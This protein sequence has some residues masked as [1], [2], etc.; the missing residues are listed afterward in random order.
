MPYKRYPASGYFIEPYFLRKYPGSSSWY[1]AW[2]D[3]GT[4][5]T[6]R[7]SL[8]T[9]DLETAKAAAARLITTHGDLHNAR[10]ETVTLAQVFNRYHEHHGKALRAGREQLRHMRYWRDFFGAN[11][12][13]ADL[14][15]ARQHAFVEHLRRNPY[16]SGTIKRVLASGAAALRW[17]YHR[18]ELQSV[19][20]V[21]TVADSEPRERVLEAD[22]IRA[23]WG[24][25]QAPKLLELRRYI[26]ILL[27]TACR[28]EAARDLTVFQVDLARNR[29]DLNPPGRARTTKG[30]PVVPITNA[31]RPWLQVDGRERLIGRAEKWLSVQW[32]AARERAGL[33]DDVL[34]YTMRHT[35]ATVLDE[36]DC[37][38][39]EIVAFM[40]WKFSNRMR[41]WYTKRRAYRP[42]YCKTVIA[43][44]DGW[45]ADLGL[46]NETAPVATTEAVSI[47]MNLALRASSLQA[48]VATGRETLETLGAGEGIRTLD[49][50]LGKVVLYP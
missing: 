46:Q 22:E 36:A 40:G 38:D 35:V 7:T 28:P 9:A 21:V 12:T 39:A 45:M 47:P 13:V 42:D 25:I 16:K 11:A 1:V 33:G 44:L 26:M 14:H 31:L 17:C 3:A 27:N 6:K 10:P 41:G 19:P 34:P 23:L 20:H 30:R 43:A 48:K 49:P 2:F 5:E 32:R 24:A 4:R 29:L 37:A 18:G 50:N 8:E 15:P